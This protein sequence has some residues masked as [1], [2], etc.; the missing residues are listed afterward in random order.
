MNVFGVD[1][2]EFERA[3]QVVSVRVYE[4]RLHPRLTVKLG[5]RFKWRKWLPFTLEV[6][7]EAPP[8]IG[9]YTIA[10]FYGA[11]SGVSRHTKLGSPRAEPLPNLVAL[12]TLSLVLDQDQLMQIVDFAM[13][14]PNPVTGRNSLASVIKLLQLGLTCS[15]FGELVARAERVAAADWAKPAAPDGPWFSTGWRVAAVS[16]FRR[17]HADQDGLA[18]EDTARSVIRWK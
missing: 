8:A 4:A 7:A 6:D 2:D 9:L 12:T 16:H 5:K 18:V 3:L 10:A 13:A 1:K 14:K 11:T 17:L 15:S